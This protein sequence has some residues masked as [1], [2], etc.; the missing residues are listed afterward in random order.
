M[1]PEVEPNINPLIWTAIEHKRL[2]RFRYNSR[3]RIVEP[4][5][6]GIHKGRIKLF[7]YQV[8]GSSSQKLP[9]WRWAE[10][11]L[12]SDLQL[13]DQ[14]F[15]GGRR[16]KSGKHQKWDKLFIR[17]KPPDNDPK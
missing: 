2:L 14:T 10:E 12:I 6:Y 1:A 15:P 16:T 4:H 9:N 13:L 3:E 5:D 17:V 7:G 11:E 8:G